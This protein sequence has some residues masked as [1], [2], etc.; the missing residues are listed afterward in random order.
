MI[1]FRQ[2]STGGAVCLHM[3]I[4]EMDQERLD[5][6]NLIS[7]FSFFLVFFFVKYLGHRCK[8]HMTGLCP[9]QKMS[10]IG[11][12]P[13]NML[14]LADSCNLAISWS[15]GLALDVLLVWAFSKYNFLPDVAFLV[16]NLLWFLICEGHNIFLILY[17][18]K[19][20][21]PF[22]EETVQ[23]PQFYPKHMILEPRRGK[24]LNTRRNIFKRL[25]KEKT[26]LDK[27]VLQISEG[28]GS[29]LYPSN[30]GPQGLQNAALQWRYSPC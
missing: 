19:K 1:F 27:E 15:A 18:S 4:A 29:D 20:E 5:K 28:T 21:I 8:K 7:T 2:G 23:K 6:S 17:L 13:R 9:R 14:T 10:C 3:S 26:M 24:V 22:V 16:H 25:W 12:R 30:F 11:L